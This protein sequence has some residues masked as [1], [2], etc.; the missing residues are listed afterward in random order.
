[1]RSDTTFLCIGF[2]TSS[3]VDS[4]LSS[5]RRQFLAGTAKAGAVVVTASSLAACATVSGTSEPV[6]ETTLGRVRGQKQRGAYAFKGIPY[7]ASTAGANRFRAPVARTPWAG[8]RDALTGGASAPQLKGASPAEF[9]WYWSSIAQDEDCLSL[10][11]FTPALRDNKKRPILVWLHGGAFSSGAGT[12]DGFD[13]SYLAQSQDVVVVAINHRLNVLGSIFTGEQ[14]NPLSPESANVGVLDQVAALKWIKANAEAFGG[15]PENV[16]IFG[17]SGGAAKVTALLGL[18][19]AKGLFQRAVV[20]SGSGLWKLASAENAARYTHRYLRELGLTSATAARLRD[21]PVEQLIAAFGKVASEQGGVSEFR[22]TL[23][24]VVFKQE[25]FDPVASSLSADIPVLIG[26]AAQEATFFLAGD[27]RNFSLSQ[28]QVFNRIKRFLR[29]N[30]GQTKQLIEAYRDIHRNATPSQ[31]LIAIAG[32]YNYRLPTL[33]TADRQAALKRAPVYAYEFD[34]SS[35]A[36]GGV[37]GAAHTAEVP[38][39]F[40]T[41]DAARALVQDSPDQLQVRDRLGAIWGAFARSGRPDTSAVANWTPYTAEKR[42]TAFIGNA[43]ATKVDPAAH[44][45]VAFASVG[46]YEYSFPVS[47]VRD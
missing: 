32:D 40:G 43:W 20:Q 24:G 38:F 26:N 6:V 5:S 46:L 1:M 29:L 16:T 3:S 41:L 15:N 25:P 34:W 22:P 4:S 13:G 37:L 12:S 14:N 31:L 17:Q 36:R 23:D 33:A 44:A 39:I 21:L 11:I 47:F 2:M 27:Q 30:D 42:T 28:D 10:S 9:A 19:A 35:P 45:R 7:A 8:V 18:P